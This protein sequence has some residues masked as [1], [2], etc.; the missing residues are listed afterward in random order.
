MENKLIKPSMDAINN[1]CAD[2]CIVNGVDFVPKENNIH[3]VV[4]KLNL[5]F[6]NYYT[7]SIG[8]S[9]WQYL[10]EIEIISNERSYIVEK[11]NCYF[12]GDI[13]V[14]KE[15]EQTFTLSIEKICEKTINR[16]EEYFI[17]YILPIDNECLVTKIE[18]IAFKTETSTNRPLFEIVFEAGVIHVF[19]FKYQEQYYLFIETEFKTTIKDFRKYQNSIIQSIAFFTQRVYG[20]GAFLVI[21]ESKDFHEIVGTEFISSVITKNVPYSCFNSNYAFLL[22]NFPHDYQKYIRDYIDKMREEYGLSWFYKDRILPIDVLAKMA[23][24]FYSNNNLLIAGSLLNEMSGYNL[25]FQ[26]GAFCTAY[27]AITS[28]LKEEYNTKP[29][30]PIAPDIFKR[31]LLPKLIAVVDES[32]EI[33][34]HQKDFIKNKIRS[35]LNTAPN[36]KK[37][38]MFFER[39]GYTLDDRD[40]SVIR[41]RN[42]IFHGHIAK[43]EG[44]M[45]DEEEQI[46]GTSLRLHKLCSILLLK[47]SGYNGDILNNEVLFGIRSA[48]ERKEPIL[49]H[50]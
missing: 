6:S 42:I 10:P 23:N 34:D 48:C 17:R 33:N 28:S 5:S 21:S 30:L 38:T 25:E 24:L 3:I 14:S 8:K 37:L 4:N 32:E 44:D 20:G 22:Y 11:G 47:M 45:N 18:N 19:E 12:G 35:N 50:I 15:T 16:E 36:D 1:L 29:T 26:A 46:F 40:L 13:I 31:A 7:E 9:F 39:Y 49:I 27:E 2:N 41:N 43:P